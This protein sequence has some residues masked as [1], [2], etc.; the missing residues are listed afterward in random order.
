MPRASPTMDDPGP[1]TLFVIVANLAIETNKLF[2][3][4]I[5]IR[6]QVRLSWCQLCSEIYDLKSVKQFYH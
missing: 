5:Q 2:K 1:N 4:N 3:S 6:N